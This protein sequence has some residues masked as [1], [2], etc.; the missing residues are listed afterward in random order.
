M[1]T[2]Q[3]NKIE[4]DCFVDVELELEDTVISGE[5]KTIISAIKYS[6]SKGPMRSL[7]RDRDANEFELLV[8]ALKKLSESNLN[9]S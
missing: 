6:L 9:K 4:Y 8:D 1:N 2:I 7:S 3:K 5:K